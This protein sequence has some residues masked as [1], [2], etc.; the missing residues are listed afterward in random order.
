MIGKRAARFVGGVGHQQLVACLEAGQQAGGDGRHPGRE[1]LGAGRIRFER[2]QR[3]FQR[4]MGLGTAPAV[5]ET[6]I[7][8]PD[9]SVEIG[10][11]FEQDR[12]GALDRRVDHAEGMITPGLRKAR[13]RTEGRQVG[14]SRPRPSHP[15]AG[16]ITTGLCGL[17]PHS[18]Q[19]PS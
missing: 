11:R 3:I 16:P 6:G 7:R 2:G 5:V 10:Q 17:A 1:Q 18:L 8:I 12:R 15:S 9:R 14:R 19:L 13:A 4:P